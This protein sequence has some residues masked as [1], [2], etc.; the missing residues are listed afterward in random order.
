MKS[1]NGNNRVYDGNRAR[2]SYH[3]I[4]HLYALAFHGIKVKS[5][6]V[7]DNF[8]RTR[9]PPQTI[10]DALG[11]IVA[12]CA[13]RSAV[14]KWQGWKRPGQ[15]EDWRKSRDHAMASA[16]WTSYCFEGPEL[17]MEFGSQS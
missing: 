11:F 5:V 17:W 14:N 2:E 3:E 13:G 8:G 1:L 9:L 6:E 15:D 12:M 10:D 16:G 7:S 4:S